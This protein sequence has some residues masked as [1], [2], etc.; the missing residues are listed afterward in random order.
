MSILI[1]EVNP[2][3]TDTFIPSLTSIDFDITGTYSEIDSTQSSIQTSKNEADRQN[4]DTPSPLTNEKIS[5]HSNS[6]GKK[7]LRLMNCCLH[8]LQKKSQRF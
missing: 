7:N 5:L 2:D 8:Y 4:N 3:N 1:C 6:T